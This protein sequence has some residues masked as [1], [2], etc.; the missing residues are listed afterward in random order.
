MPGPIPS[1][2]SS[3]PLYQ[4]NSTSLPKGKQVSTSDNQT[5]ANT[6]NSHFSNTITPAKYDS[7][8]LMITRLDE[9]IKNPIEQS[10]TLRIDSNGDSNVE[11]TLADGR[12]DEFLHDITIALIN[13]DQ[14]ISETLTDIFNKFKEDQDDES[15]AYYTRVGNFVETIKNNVDIVVSLVKATELESIK[16]DIQN[17]KKDS[18]TLEKRSQFAVFIQNIIKNDS[19]LLSDNLRGVLTSDWVSNVLQNVVTGDSIVFD[20]E[21]APILRRLDEE[22]ESFVRYLLGVLDVKPQ[23]VTTKIDTIWGGFTKQTIEDEKVLPLTSENVN[24]FNQTVFEDAFNEI[25][26]NIKAELGETRLAGL[27]ERLKINSSIIDLDLEAIG[28]EFETYIKTLDNQLQIERQA[29]AESLNIQKELSSL[30]NKNPLDTTDQERIT[31]LTLKLNK[32]NKETNESYDNYLDHPVYFLDD[33]F[34][35]LQV[36]Q[37]SLQKLPPTNE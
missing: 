30:E 19:V 27:F 16:S 8:T 10:V 26:D 15:K 24:D 4:S 21:L 1:N 9:A 6:I 7:F 31:E 12:L 14:N 17:N 33:I 22:D 23:D 2:P 32:L 18:E 29:L 5:L 37:E 3:H 13:K 35:Y 20:H 25:L 28:N 11:S 34:M 36:L